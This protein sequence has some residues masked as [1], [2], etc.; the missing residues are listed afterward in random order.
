MRIQRNEMFLQQLVNVYDLSFIDPVFI[1]IWRILCISREKCF[2]ISKIK[3]RNYYYYL[4][5]MEALKG[6]QSNMLFPL[7]FHDREF[8]FIGFLE[9]HK[10]KIKKDKEKERKK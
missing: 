3:W 5:S 1:D 2:Q 6:H 9:K 4:F 8:N 7:F 10:E